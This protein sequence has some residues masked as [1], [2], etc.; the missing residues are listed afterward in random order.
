[1]REAGLQEAGAEVEPRVTSCQARTGPFSDVPCKPVPLRE[2][3]AVG[4]GC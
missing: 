2:H 3:R 1:M 4:V